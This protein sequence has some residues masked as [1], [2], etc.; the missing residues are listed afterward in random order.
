MG[1]FVL[2]RLEDEGRTR[3]LNYLYDVVR[4]THPSAKEVV[5]WL[6]KRGFKVSEDGSLLRVVVPK[7]RGKNE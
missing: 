4:P 1:S 6:E 2:A 3:G 7:A 5:A